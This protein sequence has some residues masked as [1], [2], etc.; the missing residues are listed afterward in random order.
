[1]HISGGAY[2]S[3]RAETS[4]MSAIKK[5]GWPEIE[6]LSDLDTGGFKRSFFNYRVGLLF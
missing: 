3:F 5:L 4:F 2:R 1:M 6:D